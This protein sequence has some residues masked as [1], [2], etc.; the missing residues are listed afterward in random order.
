[1]KV[2]IQNSA[3]VWGGNEKWLWQLARGLEAR[4]HRVIL[5]CPPGSPVR[6]RAEAAGMAATS[7]R[8]AGA[9]DPVSAMRFARLLKRESPDALLLTSWGKL[10]WGGWAARRAGV[11]RVV[12]R[13]G[14]VRPP[15]R[16]GATRSALQRYVHAMIVN[17]P[18]IRDLWMHE[19]PWF[20][21]D[22]VHVVLNAVEPSPSA[23]GV[24]RSEL[25]VAPDTPLI[26]GVGH[27]FARK[28]FDLLIDAFARIPNG[29]AR[30]VIVGSGPEEPA[31]RARASARGVADRVHLLGARSDVSR[32]LADCDLFVLSSR[33]EGMANV[34]LEAMAA[35]VPVVATEVSGVRTA[36]GEVDGRPAAGWIVRPEDAASLAE[37]ITAALS[38]AKDRPAERARRVAEARYRIENW[39]GF[40]RMISHVEQVLF[41]GIAGGAV[42]AEAG[43]RVSSGAEA[44]GARAGAAARMEHRISG[45]GA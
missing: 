22:E 36:L 24:L 19:A 45:A 21:A 4:G 32:I 9:L 23:G 11:G 27:L 41:P 16:R 33:N 18:E 20:S 15:P 14:I 1:M 38:A 42:G 5:S 13:L 17:A 29:A 12:M 7:A 37:G 40:E 34:M 10:F 30:L 26:L 2:V 31:L 6:R 25:G 43:E 3:R 8:P 39:F 28:G 35:G 44:S